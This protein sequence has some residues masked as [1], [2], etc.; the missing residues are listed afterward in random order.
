MF[1]G[2]PAYHRRLPEIPRVGKYEGP[3]EDLTLGEVTSAANFCEALSN[4]HI[5]IKVS[6]EPH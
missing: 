1:R 4:K 3:G 5:M 6:R 2:G